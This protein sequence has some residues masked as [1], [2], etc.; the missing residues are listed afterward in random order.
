MAEGKKSFLLYCDLIHTVRKM[1][2]EKA[3]QL[4]KHILEYVNDNN[5]QSDDLLLQLVFEP[6]KQQLKRDLDK[7]EVE[8]NRKSN[9]GKLGNLKRWNLD[10][11]DLVIKMQM[12]IEEAEKIAQDRKESQSIAVR[13][14]ESQSIAS[15]AVSDN[16][17][18]NV[19]VK[20]NKI[21]ERKTAFGYSLKNFESQ[22][23]K[24]MLTDFFRYWSEKNK[25]GTKMKWELE[26][27]FE[28]ELRLSTWANR[29]K[30]FQSSNPQNFTPAPVKKQ[31]TN[32]ERR[33]A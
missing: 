14:N 13:Q 23:S 21:E 26:K 18:D 24:Q 20:V 2:D 31:M 7:W 22:Y 28:I 3:G 17:S 32:E 33:R 16:V 15:I 12:S 6:I 9:S 29:D 19:I 27:T 25:S 8:I 5:P 30:N 10:L 11:Y 1:P 4:L